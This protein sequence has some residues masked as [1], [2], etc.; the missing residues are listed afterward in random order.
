MFSSFTAEVRSGMLVARLRHY[1]NH[2]LIV[3]AKNIVRSQPSAHIS[4]A[5]P[6]RAVTFTAKENAGTVY[7]DGEF[8]PTEGE[9]L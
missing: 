4:I 3:A 8:S 9:F 2:G 5:W 6:S 7:P 1:E